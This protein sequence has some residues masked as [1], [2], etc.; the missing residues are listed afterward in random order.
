MIAKAKRVGVS[1]REFARLD[2]C[3]EKLVRRAIEENR[4]TPY[5][6]GSLDPSLAGSA[7]RKTNARRNTNPTGANWRSADAAA[8][9][10]AAFTVSTGADSLTANADTPASVNEAL[11]L[12]EKQAAEVTERVLQ[13]ASYSD[14]LRIKENYLALLR[15]LE[16]SIKAGS[17]IDLAAAEQTVFDL[18]RGERDAWMNWPA[19]IA[20]LM[21]ADLDFEDTDRLGLVLAAHV[22]H[23]LAALGEPQYE[24]QRSEN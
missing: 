19:R 8:T 13:G 2:G 24:F 18:F 3:D 9:P 14:A 16:Y 12:F 10:A 4:L 23:H 21:A 15:Q 7:W 22:Q 6:D 11:R 20:A 5:R 1:L 17:V